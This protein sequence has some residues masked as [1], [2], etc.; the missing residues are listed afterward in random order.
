MKH[1]LNRKNDKTYSFSC[2]N[3][4]YS[5]QKDQKN[6]EKQNNKRKIQMF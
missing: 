5:T 1:G 2:K 3:F 6:N 4:T